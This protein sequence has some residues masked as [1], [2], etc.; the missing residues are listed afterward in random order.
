MLLREIG[1]TVR[2]KR[3]ELGLTQAQLGTLAGV[4][5]GTLIELEKGRLSELGINRLQSILTTLRLSIVLDNT[6]ETRR[7]GPSPSDPID[8]AARTSSVSYDPPLP[9]QVLEHALVSGTLPENYRPHITYLIDE[10]PSGLLVKAVAQAAH[11]N[12]VPVSV[13][14]AHLAN[15]GH[16]LQTERQL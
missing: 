2:C 4:S 12:N 6:G 14:W 15:W 10:V 5:R 3:K 13:I 1:N 9:A 7:C 11:R 8:V 16:V